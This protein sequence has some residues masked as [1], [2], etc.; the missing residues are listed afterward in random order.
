MILELTEEQKEL[1]DH[2]DF[3]D[4]EV[5][6]VLWAIIDLY[7]WNRGPFIEENPGTWE[8]MVK[9]IPD[10]RMRCRGLW[11]YGVIEFWIWETMAF[12]GKPVKAISD[13]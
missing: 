12:K 13:I 9:K 4:C 2:I 6:S 10:E 1:V 3:T 5:E 8:D 7:I 11:E